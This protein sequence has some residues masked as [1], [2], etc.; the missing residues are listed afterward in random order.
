MAKSRFYFGL[1]VLV[2][3]GI[4]AW[5]SYEMNN[6]E[7][8][9]ESYRISVIVNNSNSDRWISLRLGLEQAARDCNV[10]INY[11]STGILA[12]VEEETAII[13]R[14]LENGAEGI[15]VQMVSSEE[16]A[17]KFGGAAVPALM[18]LESDVKPE[19]LYALSGPDNIEIGR[20]VADAVKKDFGYELEGKKIGILTGNDKMLSIQQRLKGLT[21]SLADTQA[22]IVW[23]LSCEQTKDGGAKELTDQMEQVDIVAA[24]ENDETEKMTDYMLNYT[25]PAQDEDSGQNIALYGVGCSEKVVYYLDRGLI[26]TLVVPNEFNLGYQS[27]Q[28]VVN[29]LK[30]HLDRANDSKV[31][32]LVV[33]QNNLYDKENQK[34]LFPI[35][36]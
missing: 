34:V 8:Q 11:V 14:E 36:Q 24:L 23:Q 4:I 27:M 20:A 2:F 15:I 32:F 7:K 19:N 17:L 6:N 16:G 9:E 10:N 30:Y 35:V 18:L 3:V 21:E 28:E 26:D 25:E 13:N 12:D 1:L 31:D 5:T 29:Q 33:D 22:D